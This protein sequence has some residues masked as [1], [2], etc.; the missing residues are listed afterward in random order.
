MYACVKVED[1][2]WALLSRRLVGQSRPSQRAKLYNTWRLMRETFSQ[3]DRQVE[4][5]ETHYQ[6]V[7]TAVEY[8]AIQPRCDAT[9]QTLSG[10]WKDVMYTNFAKFNATCPVNFEYSN[11]RK[12]DSRKSNSS[13]FHGVAKCKNC[14]KVDFYINDEPLP[15]TDVTV[16]VVVH[17]K[18]THL[19]ATSHRGRR[20]AGTQRATVAARLVCGATTPTKE[21]YGKLAGLSDVSLA[22][23]NTSDAH[24]RAVYRQA[25][26]ELRRQQERH[27]DAIVSLREQRKDWLASE[28]PPPP[29]VPGYLQAI[30][31]TPFYCTLYLNGQ[32]QLY[33]ECCD[34]DDGGVFHFD[35]TGTV[36]KDITDQKRI[37]LYSLV[38]ANAAVSIFDFLSSSHT[39]E[40]LA[41]LLELFQRDVRSANNGKTV[42][43]RYVVTDFSF[44]LI[45]AVLQAYNKSTL[46]TYL[47]V[48]MRVMRRLQTS[49]T[50]VSRTYVCLC[51]AHMLKCLSRKLTRAMPAT[52]DKSR[53]Q[54]IL[55]L[56]AALARTRSLEHAAAVYR[57][58]YI[59]LCSPVH[60]TQVRESQQFLDE[61]LL[62]NRDDELDCDHGDDDD[63]TVQGKSSGKIIVQAPSIRTNVNPFTTL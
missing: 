63:N 33:L 41:Y 5:A 62:N 48:A 54:A 21:Y 20:L 1:S 16:D 6:F 12:S 14:I 61:L 50:I 47:S 28:K 26:Y 23:G 15:N 24:S 8:S 56:F 36:V 55:A 45:N 51:V 19:P 57:N 39:T 49:A 59:F 34:A 13:F 18:C 42:Q 31:D 22:A 25:A 32:I 2:I 40:T 4:V 10:D 3:P 27:P 29:A 46:A 9:K 43:P 60:T 52:R 58:I 35:A 37:L 38:P 7:L 30:G 53:R 17:G 44:A 11:I